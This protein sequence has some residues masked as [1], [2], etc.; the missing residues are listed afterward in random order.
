MV[1]KALHSKFA[2]APKRIETTIRQISDLSTLESLMDR[3]ISSRTLNEFTASL[4]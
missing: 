1:L 3:V 2:K 4:K